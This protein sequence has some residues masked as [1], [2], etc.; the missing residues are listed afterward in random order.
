MEKKSCDL[1]VLN[2]P[3][4]IAAAENTIEV[5]DRSGEAIAAF[6]G[7]KESVAQGLFALIQRRL[8]KNS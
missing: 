8:I 6:L 3:Q 7:P 1:M 5:I 4:A 2:G